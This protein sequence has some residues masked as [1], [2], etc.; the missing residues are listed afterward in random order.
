MHRQGNNILVVVAGPTGIGKTALAIQLA[1]AFNSSII[2]ADARQIYKEMQI[3][4]AKPDANQL[5]AVPHYFIDSISIHDE[6]SAGRYEEEVIALT[7]VLFKTHEV[8]FLVGGSGFYIDAVLYGLDNIPGVDAALRKQVMDLY[9]AKGLSYLQQFVAERDP[10]YYSQVDIQNPQR[11]MRA[12]EVML[13]SGKP[14]SGFRKNSNR[15]RNF[16][17][18]QISLDADRNVLYEQINARVDR[19][20]QQ[21]LLEECRSLYPHRNLNALQT[22]GYSELFDYLEGKCTL[23]AAVE[24]IKQHTRN[25]AKRQRTWFRKDKHY[26]WFEPAATE[27]IAQFINDS[28]Q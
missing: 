4:T 26:R 15:N 19:M 25:Y 23:D 11:L 1:K 12:V 10:V 8:L 27:A 5:A 3:G 2:S 28:L 20:M 16:K 17:P 13:L 22:V 6:Y 9:A 24:R 18:V 14:Y 21:G 7:E